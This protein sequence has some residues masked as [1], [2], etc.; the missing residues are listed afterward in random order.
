MAAALYNLLMLVVDGIVVWT[1]HKAEPRAQLSAARRALI[2]AALVSLLS[3]ATLASGFG[4][5]RLLAYGVFLHGF[6]QLLALGWLWLSS[7]R[8]LGLL[9]LSL[10]GGLVV[11]AA[12]AFLIEPHWLEVTTYRI[13]HSKI[14]RPIRVGILA[15]LQTDVVGDYERRVIAELMAGAPDLILMPGDFLQQDDAV[16]RGE[17][18]RQLNTVLRQ[19]GF[20][21]PMGAIAVGGNTDSPDWPRIFEGLPVTPVETSETFALDGLQVTAL[22]LPDSFDPGLRIS[23]REEFHIAFGHGPDFALGEIGADLLVAGHTHGGQV[24]LP[25]LGPVITLSRIPRSWAT[26]RTELP[27]GRTLIVSRG[28]GME[29]AGAPRLRFLCRPQLVFVDLVPQGT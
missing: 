7:R 17:L 8:R 21:A 3:A 23:P 19:K 29:R 2:Q 28:I 12:D 27:G 4:S 24:R 1:V 25:L 9:C 13:P 6:L 18:R 16:R 11:I 10:A 5:I 14:Q 20:R 22:S 15:D 26:G